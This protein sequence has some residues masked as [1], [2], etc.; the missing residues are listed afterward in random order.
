MSKVRSMDERSEERGSE[1]KEAGVRQRSPVLD[2]GTPR[3]RT[4]WPFK[5]SL[6]DNRWY[7]NKARRTRKNPE[8]QPDDAL[9]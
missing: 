4:C 9:F 6:E 8:D 2:E 7:V 5:W 1:S 3:K